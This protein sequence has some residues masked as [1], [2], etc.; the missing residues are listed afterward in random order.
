MSFGGVEGPCAWCRR[1]SMN[2]VDE[3]VC[4]D[5][6]DDGELHLGLLVGSKACE[7]VQG[8]GKETG[9]S[10]VATCESLEVC[11]QRGAEV[12]RAEVMFD[13]DNGEGGESG[14]LGNAIAVLPRIVG[15]A[16]S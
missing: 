13:L 4:G 12:S 3:G 1:R 2:D 14:G 10:G 11:I 16:V 8:R 6:P 7:I 5:L 9:H 15:L